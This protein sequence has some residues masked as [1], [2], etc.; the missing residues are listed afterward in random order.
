MVTLYEEAAALGY[1]VCDLFGNAFWSID[2]WR[3]CVD[4]LYWDYILI[5]QEHLEAT[6]LVRA[7]IARRAATELRRQMRLRTLGRHLPLLVPAIDRRLKGL[8]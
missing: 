7:K 5:P 1:A 4:R 6:S 2:E 8:V 3:A